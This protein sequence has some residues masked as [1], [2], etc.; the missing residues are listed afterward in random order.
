MILSIEPNSFEFQLFFTLTVFLLIIKL[1]LA[2]Y[3]AK[4]LYIKKKKTGKL[5]FD[6]LLSLF[7]LIL[8]MFVSRLLY[9]QFDFIYTEFNPDKYH[10]YPSALIWQIATFIIMLGYGIFVFIVDKRLLDFKIKGILAYILIIVGVIILIY[11]VNTA[12][13]FEFLASLLLI[14]NI[15]AVIIP[16]IFIYIGLK[17]PNLRKPFY[18]MAF[19]IIIYAIGANL[20]N[21]ALLEIMISALG[22]Q[23]QIIMVFLFLVFKITGLIMIIYGARKIF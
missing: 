17:T 22:S 8:C 21:T 1:I 14:G 10:T 23:I 16:I 7:I 15:V 3:L 12:D 19:G 2:V 5:S 13:D 20:M 4:E 9:I 11:P 18:S 6:F